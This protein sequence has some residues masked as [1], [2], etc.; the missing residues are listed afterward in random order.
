MTM[1]MRTHTTMTSTAAFAADAFSC[2]R[3]AFN[4]AILLLDAAS[5]AS[6]FVALLVLV[7]LLG[8]LDITLITL[9]TLISL[10]VLLVVLLIPVRLKR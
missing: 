10:L 2:A 4:T 1:R 6:I 9:I 7:S 8:L 3:A 5:A